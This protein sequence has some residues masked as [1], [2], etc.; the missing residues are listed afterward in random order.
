MPHQATSGREYPREFSDDFA[1]VGGMREKTE[2][3]EKI[4]D[5][6]ETVLPSSGESP[7]IAVG[8]SHRR[9]S[10]AITRDFQQVL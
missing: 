7:H 4:E 6:F 3:R 5:N 1:V 9:T 8:V 10:S 2:R